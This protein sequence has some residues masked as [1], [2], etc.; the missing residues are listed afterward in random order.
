MG[1]IFQFLRHESGSKGAWIS[2]V[3]SRCRFSCHCPYDG[4]LANFVDSTFFDLSERLE[5][6]LI[7]PLKIAS[8]STSS[9]IKY[10]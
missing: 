8:I 2:Q 1:L 6:F 9:L 5:G 3:I 7:C 4:F 10:S